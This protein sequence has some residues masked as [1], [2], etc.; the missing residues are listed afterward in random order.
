M[1]KVSPRMCDMRHA[2][3]AALMVLVMTIRAMSGY[4]PSLN[5]S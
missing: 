3:G 4:S 1:P 5:R 2:A